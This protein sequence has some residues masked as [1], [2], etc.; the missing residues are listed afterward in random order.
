MITACNPACWSGKELSLKR[1]EGCPAPLSTSTAMV[2]KQRVKT[3][4][5]GGSD[6]GQ[7]RRWLSLKPPTARIALSSKF[8]GLTRFTYIF[9][10]PPVILPLITDTE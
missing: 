1:A 4:Y 10:A 8:I 7:G 2:H 3:D 6:G 9:T 5:F